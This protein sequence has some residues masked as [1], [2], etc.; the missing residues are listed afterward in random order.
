MLS[1]RRATPASPTRPVPKSAREA[2]SG[3]TAVLEAAVASKETL[4]PF[5]ELVMVK[6]PEVGSKPSRSR[7]PSPWMVRVLPLT[8]LD[9]MSMRESET[10][11]DPVKRVMVEAKAPG[12]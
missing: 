12:A 5:T 9:V 1:L 10:P 2:G 6:V 11:S 7:V 3:V 8:L 4:A